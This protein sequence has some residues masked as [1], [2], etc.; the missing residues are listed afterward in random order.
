MPNH[1]YPQTVAIANVAEDDARWR[2]C[3]G[4]GLTCINRTRGVVCRELAV[5]ELTRPVKGTK[6]R[7]EPYC[8]EHS[9]SRV[10]LDDGI[11]FVFEAAYVPPEVQAVLDRG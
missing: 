1:A 11:Y 6:G 8:A 5:L 4:E 7:R 2:S 9:F 10:E 3:A